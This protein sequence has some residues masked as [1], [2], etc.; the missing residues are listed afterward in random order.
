ME[1]AAS[2][3]GGKDST[4]AI[5][6]MLD[7]GH[8]IIAIIVSSKKDK[9][10]SWTH[11]IDRDYFKKAAEILRCEVIFTDTDVA[12]YE[13][14]FEKALMKSKKLGAQACIFGDID[15]VKHIE[16]NNRRC[17]NSGIECIHPLLF[18]SRDSIVES[19]I[20]TGIEAKIIKVDSKK[21]S[22][23][24]IGKIYGQKLIDEMKKNHIDPCGENGE[25]HT[26]VE[27]NS[28]RKMV[29]KEVYV[30]NASTA[31][32]KAS[33]IGKTM[34]DFIDNDSYSINRGSYMK[35]YN[36]S[37]KVI[38]V[39]DSLLKMTNAPKGYSCIFA[40]SATELINLVI[41]G[42]MEDGDEIIIDDRIHNSA[43]RTI[44]SLN[45]TISSKIWFPN[46]KIKNKTVFYNFEND[47]KGIEKF[48]L[49]SP[50]EFLNKD[51]EKAKY[52][53]KSI[54]EYKIEDF[55]SLI[56][57]RTKVVFLTM[58]DNITGF[59]NKSVLEI[60]KICKEKGI[61]LFIDAVQAICEVD[62]DL[63]RLEADAL[64]FSSHIGLM[65]PEGIAEMLIKDESAKK[66]NPLIYGGTGS[67]SNSPNMPV[68]MPDKF[69]AGTINLPGVIATGAAVDFIEYLG[70][71]N[72]IE[73][74]I[75]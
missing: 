22:K 13:S 43:W 11:N 18:E 30:D 47:K 10:A 52:V 37:S 19:F 63:K 23:D 71:E 12:D 15:I 29:F 51:G 21:L 70:I 28:L 4:L 58:V 54:C 33:T 66:I 34:S 7:K 42:S 5:K 9:L 59:Y 1:F 44:K 56:T 20:K 24:L 49:G 27:L 35:S 62:I 55:K 48:I 64:I 14:N 25:F 6:R 45:N 65:G 57:D 26:K 60:G 50:E 31:F 67:Q 46:Y 41:R 36:L 69:E 72:I 17:K 53:E 61:L 74:N 68:L 32:P 75:G 8:R 16:W 38:D 3:S 2:F 73:K 40:P 39:R